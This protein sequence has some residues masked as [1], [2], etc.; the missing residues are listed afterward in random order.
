MH[1]DQLRSKSSEDSRFKPSLEA[2]LLLRM[3]P[4][5]PRPP[6]ATSK[7]MSAVRATGNR[8]EVLFRKRLWSLGFRYRLY[9]RSTIGR[10]D[11]ILSRWRAAVFVDG[12]FWHGR[13]FLEKGLAA[14]RRS[15]RTSRREWWVKK[16]LRNVAKSLRPQRQPP[17]DR[18]STR[19]NSSH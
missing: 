7:L 10:P 17:S 16:I 1:Y 3:K 6:E 8:A 5:R 2:C 9:D 13:V 15:L 4:H 19:L 14:L 18:K 11:L 12:D